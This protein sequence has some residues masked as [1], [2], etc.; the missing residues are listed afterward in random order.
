MTQHGP[1]QL[2]DMIAHILIIRLFRRKNLRTPKING[3]PL[4]Q[5]KLSTIKYYRF[6]RRKK[7]LTGLYDYL[8]SR[9]KS[10]YMI[11]TYR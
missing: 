11:N 10:D 8:K 3:V 7:S 9:K 5:A 6:K 4:S 1:Q 2:Y